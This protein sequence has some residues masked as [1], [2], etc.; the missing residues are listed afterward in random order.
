MW[1]LTILQ[2]TAYGNVRCDPGLLY[3]PKRQTTSIVII[4]ADAHAVAILKERNETMEVA[5]I[6]SAVLTE[7]RIAGATAN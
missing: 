5:E 7:G 3:L 6:L 1:M 2:N 4:V